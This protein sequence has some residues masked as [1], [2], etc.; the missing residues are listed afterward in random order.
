MLEVAIFFGLVAAGALF[1]YLSEIPPL[2]EQKLIAE[3][4]PQYLFV[5][6]LGPEEEFETGEVS[7]DTSSRT[8]A[9]SSNQSAH[10]AL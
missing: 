6:S 5:G 1:E 9:S 7:Q 3:N 2:R 10:G 4:D 8:A